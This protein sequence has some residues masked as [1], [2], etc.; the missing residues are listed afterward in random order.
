MDELPKNEDGLA[1]ARPSEAMA[2]PAGSS[3]ASR[4][5]SLEARRPSEKPAFFRTRTRYVAVCQRL[6]EIRQV[7]RVKIDRSAR[8]EPHA[9]GA[10]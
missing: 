5:G 4:I 1:E 6:T 8:N 7:R 10:A 9:V 3:A 2:A